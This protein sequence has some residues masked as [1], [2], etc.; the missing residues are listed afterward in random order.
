M[1]IT[2]II[3]QGT[4]S[5]QK[6][7][8]EVKGHYTL[9][10]EDLQ[11]R[12]YR[13]NGFNDAD[14]MVASYIDEKNWPYKSLMFDPRPYTVILEKSAR[15]IGAKPKGRLVPREG[16]DTLGAY[17]NNELL[18]YQ[19]DD[20]S[21]LGDPMIAKWIKM[22]QGTRKY[23][24]KFGLCLWRYECKIVNGKREVFYDG[25]DFK[26]CDS[27][28]A[29]PNPSYSTVQRWFQYREFVTLDDL[30]NVNDTA[31]KEPVYKN[32]DILREALSATETTGGG[33]RQSTTTFNQNKQMKGL[34]DFLGRDKVFKVIE[35]VTEYRNDRWITFAP[36]YGVVIRD[37]PNPY[38][39]GEI[40]VV[41]LCYYP[42]EDDLY[43]S[44][45]LEPVS[46]IMRGINALFSQYIDNIAIDLYP[47]LMVNPVNVRM[48][49]LDFSPDA[50]WLMNNPGKDVVRMETSTAAT[51]NFQSA[52]NIML[53]SLL[54]ALGESS[55]G[56]SQVNSAQ[57]TGRVTAT[58][59]K[60]TAFTRNV[61]D[62]MNQIYLAEALKKQIMFWHSMNQQF[63]FGPGETAKVIRVVGK[64]AQDYF[65][66]QG[67]G[68]VRPTAQDSASIAAGTLNPNDVAPGPRFNV[69]V[70]GVDMPKFQPDMGGQGGNLI[71]EPADVA[72]NYD[73]VPDIET[74]KAPS[75]ADVEQKMTMILGTISN[76]VV[77]QGLASEQT[78]PKFKE[79][80]VKLY[81]AT[82]V[83]KDA[84][85]YFE[86][87]KP[88]PPT[89][90]GGAPGAPT[91]PL[92]PGNVQ[93]GGMAPGNAPVAPG[94]N[95]TQL[96]GPP[97]GGVGP[98]PALPVQ[99][100]MG[101]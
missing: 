27:R 56:V 68:D 8:T 100:G 24:K 39:H 37:I 76:P 47:P 3:P 30:K 4:D 81:E 14:K 46:K 45:E 44:S 94:P 70:G 17:I 55:Q 79:I 80:L 50:K 74:M 32:L 26:I 19:W 89:L 48:H 1:A 40:P 87:V 28:N 36:K 75:N 88:A 20:N 93:P 95:Q 85:A 58:E 82:N 97:Q 77:L 84:E 42:Q 6:T 9:A 10:E 59:I 65:N 54:N 31:R 92:G 69:N 57:D 13:K 66:N 12:I 5:E 25:P 64:D 62:N 41:E 23:A 53:G 101:I 86:D 83:I 38:K 11:Q 61:R 90:P 73:Y 51:T 18:S 29:L 60:D 15:L 7:F 21:R 16:G 99:G 71:I 33:N 34:T 67:L 98:G 43:G 78:K 72:G 52:Y 2:P 63:M 22:D 49:T 96:G 91:S 35:I